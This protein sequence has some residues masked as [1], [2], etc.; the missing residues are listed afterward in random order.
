MGGCSRA[1]KS[2]VAKELRSLIDSCQIVSQ[3]RY[4]VR[5]RQVTVDGKQV[6]SE[7]EPECTDHDAFALAIADASAAAA[8]K[9]DGSK[10]CY[11]IAEGFQLVFDSKVANLLDNLF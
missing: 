6:S 4:W 7:E 11:V 3:D 2:W 9:F 8:K 1:G 5:T 10:S